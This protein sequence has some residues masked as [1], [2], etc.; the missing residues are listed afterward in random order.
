MEKISKIAAFILLCVPFIAHAQTTF[1]TLLSAV[2]SVVGTLLPVVIS[3]AILAFLW[4]LARY[5]RSQDSPEGREAARS[6]MTWGL[7]AIFIMVSLWGLVNLL[8]TAVFGGS[9]SGPTPTWPQIG[10]AGCTAG[11]SG[12]A[13]APAGMGS[14]PASGICP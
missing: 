7:I 14:C 6:I 2:V 9:G 11:N 3:F 10:G 12:S 8:E 4:G 5:I 1:N 13:C